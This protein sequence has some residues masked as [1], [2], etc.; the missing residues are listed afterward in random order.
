MK[1]KGRRAPRAEAPILVVAPHSTFYDALAALWDD[2]RRNRET[3]YV[4]SRTENLRV[5]LLGKI[6]RFAQTVAVSREDPESRQRAKQ[7]II[8]RAESKE[9]QEEGK[10]GW[11]QLMIFP[12]GSTSNRR[13]LMTFAPGAFN[14]GKT[15]QPVVLRLVDFLVW[16]AMKSS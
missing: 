10:G 9:E 5:P 11:P 4:V 1:V 12:E 8:R 3:P 7:E 15:V 16:V 6:L 13:A 14:P 2:D